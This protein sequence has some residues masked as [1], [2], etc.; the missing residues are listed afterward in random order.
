M[1]GLGSLLRC[2]SLRC[3]FGCRDGLL[4]RLGGS[5]LL[6]GGTDGLLSLGL[7]HLRLHVSLSQDVVEGGTDN[8]SLELCSPA[9]AL[10]CLLN[11]NTLFVLSS[12]QHRPGGLSRV[13]A[14]QM[15]G[16]AFG[17]HEG[18]HFAIDLYE[19]LPVAGVDFV[20]AERTK[21]DLHLAGDLQWGSGGE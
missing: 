8:G 18:E 20:T 1:H 4:G 17:V 16:L 9:G 13:A 2:L 15:G 21:F 11:L 7:S 19:S 14:H 6:L 10:L 12:V 3:W 5:L